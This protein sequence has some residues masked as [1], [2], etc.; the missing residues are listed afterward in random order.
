MK[1]VIR[2]HKESLLTFTQ[3]LL[4]TF[5][6]PLLLT[7]TQLLQLLLCNEDKILFAGTAEG[8]VCAHMW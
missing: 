2:R 8:S 5:T 6:Q 1:L 3:L 4:L 7:F